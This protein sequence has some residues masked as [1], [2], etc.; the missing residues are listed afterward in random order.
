MRPHTGMNSVSYYCSVMVTMY[1]INY[2]FMNVPLV[3][4][5]QR[6]EYREQTADCEQWFHCNKDK[7]STADFIL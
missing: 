2:S 5:E 4:T 7:E 1:P 3:S 6:V